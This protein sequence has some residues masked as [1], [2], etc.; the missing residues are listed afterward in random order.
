MAK[1]LKKKLRYIPKNPLKK[2]PKPTLKRVRRT[3]RSPSGY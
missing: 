2:L 3:R 1:S